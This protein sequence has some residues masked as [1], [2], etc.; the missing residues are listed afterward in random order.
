MAGSCKFDRRFLLPLSKVETLIHSLS[1]I[2][3]D[4]MRKCGTVLRADVALSPTDGFVQFFL[5]SQRSSFRPDGPFYLDSP[6][7]EVEASG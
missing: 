2:Q 4:L 3:K 5:L 7:V 1:V 6:S